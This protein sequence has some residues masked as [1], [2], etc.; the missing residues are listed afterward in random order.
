MDYSEI[1]HDLLIGRTPEAADYPLLRKLGV[2]LVINMRFERRPSPDAHHPPL[3]TLWLPTFDSPF[4][5]IPIR[6]LIRGVEAALATFEE[7]KRV[8]A[9]CAAGA[10]RGVAMGGAILIAQGY[11]AEEAMQLI[12]SR[13]GAADPD[14]W[15]IRRR[16]HKFAQYWAQH[17]QTSPAD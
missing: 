5:P 6:M 10:H 12:K 11:S 16:I 1:T 9:H 3:R 7:G 14:I 13:R 15:Y 8:Y 2:G 17:H 4:F